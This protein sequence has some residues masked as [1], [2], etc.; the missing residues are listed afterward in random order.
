VTGIPA[1]GL[2]AFFPNEQ[3]VRPPCRARSRKVHKRRCSTFLHI[4]FG[5][6]PNEKSA[7]TLRRVFIFFRT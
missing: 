6:C 4:S 7:E 1:K 3:A 5:G 2:A